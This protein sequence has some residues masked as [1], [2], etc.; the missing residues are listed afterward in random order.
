MTISHEYAEELGRQI[1]ELEAE[2]ERLRDVE[3]SERDRCIAICEG[4]MERFEGMEI[5]YT[6][7]REYACDAINDIIDLIRDGKWPTIK[8]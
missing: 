6:S 3:M 5:Q 8:E 7:A 1:D 2:N 4:W